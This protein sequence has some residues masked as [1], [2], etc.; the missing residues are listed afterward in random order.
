MIFSTILT[1]VL[2]LTYLH[3]VVKALLKVV[4]QSIAKELNTHRR[5]QTI[6]HS[7]QEGILIVQR[8]SEES[9]VIF[10]NEIAKIIFANLLDVSDFEQKS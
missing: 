5:I 8:S 2:S 4:E 10:A 6:F 1:F 3:F 7:L 9:K